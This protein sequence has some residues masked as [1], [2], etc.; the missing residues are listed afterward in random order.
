M[1]VPIIIDLLTNMI[2]GSQL[3][4]PPPCWHVCPTYLTLH[5]GPNYPTW[6]VGLTHPYPTGHVGPTCPYPTC[7]VGPTRPL[8]TWYVGPAYPTWHVGPTRQAGVGPASNS[9]RKIY[10]KIV[11]PVRLELETS[12]HQH[13]VPHNI[14]YHLAYTSLVIITRFG[15]LYSS[16]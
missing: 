3:K 12:P 14:Y 8:P 1:W 11:H 6:H 15:L 16:L 10:G 4:Q 7:Q 2:Y 5:V 13:A 9:G